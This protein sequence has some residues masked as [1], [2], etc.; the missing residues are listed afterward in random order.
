MYTLRLGNST[1]GYNEF[2]KRQRKLL[3]G[4]EQLGS[5][6]PKR[7]LEISSSATLPVFAA[8]V[9]Q[10]LVGSLT[11]FIKEIGR[12]HLFNQRSPIQRR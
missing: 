12:S 9:L 6:L 7:V 2:Q 5:K 1:F 10:K 4:G 8:F 11:V 3:A